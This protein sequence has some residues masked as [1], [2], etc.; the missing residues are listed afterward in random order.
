M[1]ACFYLEEN[2]SR[3]EPAKLFGN[4][5]LRKKESDSATRPLER[6]TLIEDSR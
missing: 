2:T 5:T 1:C 3:P 6:G 4:A